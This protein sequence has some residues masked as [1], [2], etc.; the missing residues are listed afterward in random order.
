M[1]YFVLCLLKDLPKAS[2]IQ[3]DSQVT[4]LWASFLVRFSWLPYIYLLNQNINH[5]CVS[6]SQGGLGF[7]AQ[8]CS[9]Q[10]YFGS[11]FGL[12]LIKIFSFS[13]TK[14][15]VYFISSLNSKDLLT[16]G[17]HVFFFT[18]LLLYFKLHAA[19]VK[20]RK[21]KILYTRH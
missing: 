18:S 10:T 17:Q 2:N 6:V 11:N 20:P 7:H 16:A 1:F 9:F 21:Y 19:Y 15:Y 13:T 14:M 3:S 4:S 12:D 5:V 8:C